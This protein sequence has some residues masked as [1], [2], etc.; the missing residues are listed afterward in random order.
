MKAIVVLIA[1]LV[2]LPGCALLKGAIPALKEPTAPRAAIT[3]LT[4]HETWKLTTTVSAVD[5]SKQTFASAPSIDGRA[6]LGV[7]CAGRSFNVSIIFNS[8]VGFGD[9]T[10]RARFDKGEPDTSYWLAVSGHGGSSKSPLLL[11]RKLLLDHKT[12]VVEFNPRYGGAEV[13]TFALDG[14]A[15][16]VAQSMK[17]CGFYD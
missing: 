6:H 11:A 9:A 15:A 17:D 10:V 12:L 7:A 13:V 16:A 3:P 5:D 1:A 8:Y 4:G 2:S 14:A